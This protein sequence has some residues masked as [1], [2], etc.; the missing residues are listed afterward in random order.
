MNIELL[1]RRSLSA[2]L[3]WPSWEITGCFFLKAFVVSV[4]VLTSGPFAI[5]YAV[6]RPNTARFGIVTDSHYADKNNSGPT[7]YRESLDK[8]T[9][10]VEMMNKQE[11]DFL[12]EIGDFIDEG[13]NELESISYLQAIEGIFQ[14]FDGPIYHV[15]GNHDANAMTK[16]QFLANIENTNITPSDSKYYSFEVN[17]LHF[18][19]LDAYYLPDGN[20]CPPGDCNYVNTNVPTAELDW[21]ESD[22]ASAT[23][24]VVV[25]IHPLLDG[26][27]AIYVNN[28]S[29]VRQI[30]EDSEKVL[31]VFQGHFHFGDYSQI[32]GIHYY[33]LHAMVEGSGPENNSYAIV[34]VHPDRSIT[35]SAY[36]QAVR[37]EFDG[38]CSVSDLTGD[39][40]VNLMDFAVMAST[41]LD[42]G[43]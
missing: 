38:R 43:M 17:G 24:P 42:K 34:E 5:T 26:S 41:W 30:L 8:M 32:G 27:G 40:E 39:C 13:P 3:T 23:G 4:I 31:A 20:D 9:E 7:Y 16:A 19:I 10:C 15:F 18:A 22:L 2:L 33:T 29:D 36:R 21:L 12:I 37:M 25:F 14:Q 11:V 35:V 1:K 6:P 28:S